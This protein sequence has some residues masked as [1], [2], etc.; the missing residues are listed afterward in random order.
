MVQRRYEGT[1]DLKKG[2]VKVRCTYPVS[3]S[4]QA[5]SLAG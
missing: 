2:K 3:S 1:G 5:G 4:M